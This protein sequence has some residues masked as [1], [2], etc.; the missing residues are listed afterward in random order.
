MMLMF[1][2]FAFAVP[3]KNMVIIT[4]ISGK[5]MWEKETT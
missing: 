5:K 4:M 1:R 2:P 3:L